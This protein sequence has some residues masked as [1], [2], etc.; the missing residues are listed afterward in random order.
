MGLHDIKKE[1]YERETNLPEKRK[2]TTV[3]NVNATE[4][5]LD[6]TEEEQMGLEEE[7][8]KSSRRVSRKSVFIGV[9]VIALI[10]T[11][12]SLAVFLD[13]FRT[14]SF[15]E[16]RVSIEVSGPTEVVSGETTS[17][18]IRIANN[19]LADLSDV[20][21]VVQY[22]FG[23]VPQGNTFTSQDGNQRG[24]IQIGD[25]SGREKKE[26]PLSGKFLGGTGENFYIQTFLE[27]RKDSGAGRFTK[28]KQISVKLLTSS[29]GLSVA[30][31][32]EAT[33]GEQVEYLVEYKNDTSETMYNARLVATLS[34]FFDIASAEPNFSQKDLTR[35]TW[36]LGTL[37]AGEKGEVRIRGAYFQEVNSK[38]VFDVKLGYPQ[39]NGNF[40]TISEEEV[41]TAIIP[42]L[43]SMDIQSSTGDVVGVGE[44]VGFVL[45]YKNTGD[46]GL[47]SGV[48]Q[49]TFDG[50]I[51]DFDTLSLR[52]ANWNPQT[53]TI[54][55][56]A[57]DVPELQ[58]LSPQEEGRLNFSLSAKRAIEV[59]GAN[60]SNFEA[61]V[62]ALIDSPD[63]LSRLGLENVS[64]RDEVDLKLQTFI[65]VAFDVQEKD[66]GES[67]RALRFEKDVPIEL[68]V[69]IRLENPYNDV[70][71]GR[72]RINIPGEVE[73]E[74]FVDGSEEETKHFDERNKILEWDLGKIDAGTGVYRD[75]R[76][77]G[78][79]I[80]FTPRAYQDGTQVPILS[81]IDF[82]GKDM[83]ID[84]DIVFSLDD[85]KTQVL[86]L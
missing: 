22:P 12:V 53:N 51:W 42:S 79:T 31:T 34:S 19:N 23:F 24:I 48:A 74:G 29:V 86:R 25:F 13:V 82:S 8:R 75:A 36:E 46:I 73:W 50:E 21:V 61:S 64:G 10:G 57:A 9:V 52:G 41:V 83:F 26:I 66:S 54:T 85:I 39:G 7:D 72:L 30:S 6:V 16:D 2:K 27:Y 43:L 78:F 70:T 55:W 40:Y 32:L 37:D 11:V 5:P 20:R 47:P 71:N 59:S 58:E 81:G 45:N 84:E 28:E 14:I 1:L 65:D 56:R 17:Y 4:Q 67:L 68:D 3:Y 77:L 44:T 76:E 69:R 38:G 63:A 49:V 62:Q 80:E 18:T 33:P 15:D 35:L 60:D